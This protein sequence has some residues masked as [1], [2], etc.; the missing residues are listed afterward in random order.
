MTEATAIAQLDQR[1]FDELARS[2][3]DACVK[4]FPPNMPEMALAEIGNQGWSLLD[5][6]LP[7]PAAVLS[8]SALHDNS[9]WMRRFIQENGLRLAPHGKTTMAPQLFRL[10]HEDGA[11][12]ITVSTVHHLAVCLKFGFPRVLIANE[13]VGADEL[14]Y[15]FRALVASPDLEIFCLV[16]SV[17]GAERLAAA[18]RRT[19]GLSRLG[20]L[21]EVGVPD[22]RCGCRDMD[23]AVEVARAVVAHGLT[24]RGVE[25][26]EGILGD[27]EAATAFVSFLA[28]AARRCVEEGLFGH[29]A[30][31]LLSAGGSVFYDTVAGELLRQDLG[32]PSEVV[33]RC[34][35]YLSHDSAMVERA[36]RAIRARTAPV[37]LPDGDPRPALTVWTHVQSRPEP[38]RA[39]LAMGRRDVSFDADLPVPLR[40]FRK[41]LHAKPAPVAPELA[42]T[43]LNDQHCYLSCAHDSDLAVG[44]L[45]EFGISHPCTTFDK[46][47]LLYV[48]DDDLKVIDAVRTFF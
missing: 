33:I 9:A 18:G 10:Q 46:W 48:V 29:G 40:W 19:G 42:V 8:S 16:D 2:R 30:P 43:A 6:D 22:G 45:M 31:V 4:G 20:V 35:C 11:W 44:D 15:V 26:F 14:D 25:G 38:G 27:S 36:Y 34:G 13:L 3:V 23:T 37:R 12:A 28:E 7:F 21:L 39:I 1:T 5:E 32:Q 24:L 47:Q 17:A 41:G